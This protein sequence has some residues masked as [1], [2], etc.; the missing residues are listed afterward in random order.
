MNQNN[1]S[2]LYQL[3]WQFSLGE[4]EIGR[5]GEF[6]L[7]LTQIEERETPREQKIAIVK[8]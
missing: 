6:I 2:H 1:C 8:G 3:G 5:V 7:G 4:G